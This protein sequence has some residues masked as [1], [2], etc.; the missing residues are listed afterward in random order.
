MQFPQCL[1]T[2]VFAIVLEKNH[3]VHSKG[4]MGIGEL[5]QS[6]A[7]VHHSSLHAAVNW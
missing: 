6:E 7:S 2:C 4:I 5:A 3:V 1:C